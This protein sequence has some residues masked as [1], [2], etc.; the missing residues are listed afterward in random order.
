MQSA[1]SVLLV[2]NLVLYFIITVIASWAVNHA[3]EKSFEMGN[4]HISNFINHIQQTIMHSLNKIFERLTSLECV[5]L[6]WICSINIDTASPLVSDIL[7]DWK[8]GDGILCHLLFDCWGDGNGNISHRNH[9]CL[10]MECLKRSHSICFLSCNL[11]SHY[12]CYG[13]IFIHLFFFLLKNQF[14]ITFQW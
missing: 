10:K 1:I 11:G 4:F 5:L 2:L 3:M 14:L 6:V 12:T 7:P 8:H 13:V 9:Q